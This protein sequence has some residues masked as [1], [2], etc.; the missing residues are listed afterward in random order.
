MAAALPPSCQPAMGVLLD[1]PLAG[2]AGP[3][4]GAPPR[5]Q[6]RSLPGSLPGAA[7]APPWR[8]Q[9]LERHIRW[10]PPVRPMG[11]GA[12][13]VMLRLAATAAAFDQHALPSLG[14]AWVAAPRRRLWR[15]AGADGAPGNHVRSRVCAGHHRRR[16]SSGSHRQAW[17]LLT[18]ILLSLVMASCAISERISS[19]SQHSGCVARALL[20]AA[21][22]A[23]DDAYATSARSRP[24]MAA[25]LGRMKAPGGGFTMHDDGEIDIRGSYTALAVAHILSI[26][27]PDLLRGVGNYLA[28]CQTY[29]GGTGGE[30]GNEAHGGQLLTCTMDDFILVHILRPR[31]CHSRRRGGQAPL[32]FLAGLNVSGL[33]DWAVF[34][35]GQVE[36]GFQ[37]RTNKLV[38]GCYSFWQGGLILLLN[39]LMP[40]LTDHFAVPR[41]AMRGG[42]WQPQESRHSDREVQDGSQGMAPSC[43]NGSVGSSD[44]AEDDVGRE[45]WRAKAAAEHEPSV[46]PA[47]QT[48]AAEAGE[49]NTSRGGQVAGSVTDSANGSSA[50]HNR[51]EEDTARRAEVSGQGEAANVGC[52]HE[53]EAS[54]PRAAAGLG[55]L[56]G[57]HWGTEEP[58]SPDHMICVIVKAAELFPHVSDRE[59][60]GRHKVEILEE[61]S[62]DEVAAAGQG[63]DEDGDVDVDDGENEAWPGFNSRALQ[64]YLLLCSQV[65][66]GGLR[67]KPGKARDYYHT[68]YCLSGL[69]AAQ[70]AESMP[71]Q[72]SWELDDTGA[73]WPPPPPCAVLGPY[74]NLL[75]PAEPLCTL[76][77]TKRLVTTSLVL[78]AFDCSAMS[79][80]WRE[81]E[82][83]D[84]LNSLY[85]L[86]CPAEK[87]DVNDQVTLLV[88]LKLCHR[89][90]SFLEPRISR[91]TT[92]E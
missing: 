11:L 5:R 45:R 72:Y 68:C 91:R 25:F 52:Q 44:G 79:I 24:A 29:E 75:E 74:S 3:P 71:H 59:Q 81:G 48:A 21:G 33:Q 26:T 58:A 85:L 67:D 86:F 38:D 1:P 73:P 78:A 42:L 54:L 70:H 17:S 23:A 46:R 6:L 13:A 9:L 66:D 28:N 63:Q 27:T 37:G 83:V 62:G 7:L 47:S 2:A 77:A 49:Q 82:E 15:R 43:Q 31:G 69:S 8:P 34:R 76:S 41:K 60:A 18:Q 87:E 57:H 35:Q 90:S 19:P 32:D 14:P 65:I 51:Q 30:P 88:V 22:V 10:Q 4:A 64:A 55:G 39:R 20:S 40:Q 92:P 89:C 16:R 84:L 12:S 50:H 61:G 53:E 80:T 56:G 36:G